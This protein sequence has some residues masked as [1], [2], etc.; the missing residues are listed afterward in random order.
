[1]N[2]QLLVGLVIGLVL[3]AVASYGIV[4]ANTNKMQMTNQMTPESNDMG[5]MNMGGNELMT[6]MNAAL[7]GKTGEAFDKEFITQM[8]VHHQ[9]AIA[10][11]NAAKQNAGRQE[12]KDLADAIISAQTTEISQMRQWQ[13]DWGFAQ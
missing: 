5:D 12:I 8:I 6:D 13:K 7:D 10:M 4:S 1:M 2:K 11:A 9:G 3:G